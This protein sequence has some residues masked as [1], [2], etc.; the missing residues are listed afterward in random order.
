MLFTVI[1][2]LYNKKAYIRRSIDSV[3]AQ[4]IQNFEIIVVDDG[5]TDGGGQA[6]ESIKDS[7]IRLIRQ[8]NAGAAEARNTGIRAGKGEWVAFLDADDLW[9]PDN[10]EQHLT[11][12]AEDSG[13]MWS[14]GLYERKSQHGLCRMQV[15]TAS[16]A[17]LMDNGVVRDALVLLPNNYLWTG[18]MVIRRSVFL[19]V[20]FMDPTLRTAEDLDMWLRIACVYPCIAYC[21]KVISVYYVDIADSLTHRKVE[22]PTMLPQF[23]FAR[24]HLHNLIILP[25]GRQKSIYSLL[26]VLVQGGIRKIILTGDRKGALQMIEEFRQLLGDRSCTKHKLL[27]LAPVALLRLGFVIMKKMKKE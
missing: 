19:E 21:P 13:L 27:T 23:Q 9:Y 10:L 16:L 7:R 5:S 2:P 14:A 24:K 18:S 20:G 25:A 15:D 3:L 22:N 1:I 17:K 26:C 6:V 8:V 11:L 4:T 12:L